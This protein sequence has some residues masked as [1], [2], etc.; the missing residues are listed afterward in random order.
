MVTL[1]IKRSGCLA[2]PLP[3]GNT[4]ITS[5]VSKVPMGD[6]KRT[7]GTQVSLHGSEMAINAQS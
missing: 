7:S 6:G 5:K 4:S 3:S 1:P 2:P